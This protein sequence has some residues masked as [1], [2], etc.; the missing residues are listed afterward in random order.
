MEDNDK[1]EQQKPIIDQVKE[2]VETYIQLTRL[3]AVEKGTSIIA[4]IVADIFIVMCLSVTCIFALLTLAFYLSEVFH[5]FW[6]GFGT[7]TLL[8][9]IIAIIINV[10]RKSLERPVINVLLKRIFK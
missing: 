8:C 6:K 7:V 1:K 5:S 10:S 9:L 3:K 4:S 2:Y